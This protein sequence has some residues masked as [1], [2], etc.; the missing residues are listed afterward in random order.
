MPQP[1]RETN[2]WRQAGLATAIPMMLLAGVVVGYALAWVIRRMTGWGSWVDVTCV[3]LGFVAG[4]RES[5]EII[6]RLS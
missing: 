3:V 4:V 1:P 2:P 5:I 6:R